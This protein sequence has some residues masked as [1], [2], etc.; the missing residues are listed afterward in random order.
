MNN[1]QRFVSQLK[2]AK[3][4]RCIEAGYIHHEPHGVKALDQKAGGSSLQETRLY[5]FP[6]EQKKILYLITIGN[7]ND[8]QDDIKLA[9]RFVQSLNAP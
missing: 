4:S 3:N 1:L 7:K 9:T 2:Y 5:L 6:E 8:Q